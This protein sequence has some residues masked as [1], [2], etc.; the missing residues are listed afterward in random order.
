MK[1]GE[2]QQRYAGIATL[3]KE[4]GYQT[5]F[6]TTHD[7]HFDNMQGFLVANDFDV[8]IGQ[9]DYPA[10][11]AISS[12]GVPDHVMYERAAA[13][14]AGLEQPFL[15]LLLTGSHHGPFIVPEDKPFRR[16]DRSEPNYLRYNAF[17]YADWALGWFY[18]R[19]QEATWGD[20]CLLVITG[21]HG[22]TLDQQME[23]DLNL[24]HVPLLLVDS[25]LIEPGVNGT[26]GGQKDI[27]ATIMALLGGEW[28]N[29]TLGANLRAPGTYPHALF[30]EGRQSGFIN[31]GMFLHSGRRGKPLLYKMDNL[32]EPVEDNTSLQMLQGNSDALLAAAY[33]LIQERRV[34][35]PDMGIK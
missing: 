7:P 25:K 34:G 18:D 2:G 8:V 24:Y 14:F 26:L 35:L 32:M 15:A 3:L 31:D 1:R 29:N 11:E 23:M 19:M 21:D 27:V 4:R 12:L 17:S 10:A 28:I 5:R 33:H 20:S 13:D 22:V 30:V 6:Y 16:F 9:A